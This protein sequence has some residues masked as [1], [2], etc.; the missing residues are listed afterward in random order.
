[1]ILTN[2]E[3]RLFAVYCSGSAA[4]TAA[5]VRE[6]L[7][8]IAEA[9]ENAAAI[10]LLFKLDGMDEAAFGDLFIESGCDRA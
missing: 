1:M 9:D 7:P 2:E 10:G 3:R 4:E 8:D 5:V 6:A